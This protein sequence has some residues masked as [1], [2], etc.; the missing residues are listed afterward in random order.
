M[1]CLQ[2][3][4]VVEQIEMRT[5][6]LKC[7]KANLNLYGLNY[8]SY[9]QD[10]TK[11]RAPGMGS[12]SGRMSTERRSSAG[13]SPGSRGPKVH[14]IFQGAIYFN[15][16]G[17]LLTVID[18]HLLLIILKPSSWGFVGFRIVLLLLASPSE[19]ASYSL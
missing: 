6:V 15:S 1:R 5:S 9:S 14:F 18:S 16:E 7:E 2:A 10:I 19:A 4:V 3:V 8:G 17:F 12:P 13:M 11:P